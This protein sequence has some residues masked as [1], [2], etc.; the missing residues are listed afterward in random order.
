MRPNADGGWVRDL[1]Q[2]AAWAGLAFLAVVAVVVGFA[3]HTIASMGLPDIDDWSLRGSLAGDEALL[4][5]AEE[6]W[7]ASGGP[8]VPDGDVDPLYAERSS[9]LAVNTVLVVMAGYTADDRPV[10][11]FVTS[12]ATTGTPGTEQLFVRAVSFPEEQP[13][14]VG[15]VAATQDPAD[16]AFPDGGSLAFALAKPETTSVMVSTTVPGPRETGP[17]GDTY[18]RFLPRGAGAWNSQINGVESGETPMWPAA[19]LRDAP[20]TRTATV[21]VTTARYPAPAAGDLLMTQYRLFGVVKD[22]SGEVDVGAATWAAHGEVR[23]DSGIPG[24]LTALPTGH[25]RFMPTGPGTITENDEVLFTSKANPAVVVRVGL[26]FSHDGD[27]RV[28]RPG[29]PPY[30]AN[31]EVQVVTPRGR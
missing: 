13:L 15:F 3:V 2:T 9:S 21:S 7:R 25:L 18:W 12:P 30:V 24:L 26:M 4:D 17:L 8:G 31:Q 29:Y 19:G 1:L 6:V 23:T 27:W 5:R 28:D 14:A 10:V 20:Q 11:A 22:A 16:A